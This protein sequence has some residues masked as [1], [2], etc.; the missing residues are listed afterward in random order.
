[1]I[2]PRREVAEAPRPVHGGPVG[3]EE[4]TGARLDFSHN[5]NAWGPAPSV[6]AAARAA[7]VADYPDPDAL[8][9]RRA[10]AER[11]GVAAERVRFAAGATELIHRVCRTFLRPGDPVLVPGPTFGEYARAAA[12]AGGTVFRPW[13]SPPEHRLA[14]GGTLPRGSTGGGGPVR[15]LRS[16]PPRLMFVCAPNSPTGEEPHRDRLES[17]VESLPDDSLLV[18]DESF[19]SFSAGTFTRPAFPENAR[20]LHVRSLTKDFALAGLRA[21]LAF[22]DPEVLDAMDR[23][24][25]PWS[26]SAPAQAAAA[27]AMNDDAIGAL[28]RSVARL[29]R[30]RSRLADRLRGAGWEPLP[31]STNFLLCRVGDGEGIAAALLEEGIRVREC[32]S[33]GLPDHVRVA[34]RTPDENDALVRAV[35]ALR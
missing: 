5:V 32:G 22:G 23:A 28:E 15:K 7:G 25:V 19:R 10:A 2:R 21:G 6:A 35:E 18:L 16:G 20:V 4:G 13:G 12:L 3:G 34:V 26:G 30:D 8:A 29:A 24:A 11:W 9:P 14:L 31:S 1:M 17:L 27:A 33:F